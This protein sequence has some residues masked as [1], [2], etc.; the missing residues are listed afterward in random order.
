MIHP[1]I[2]PSFIDAACIIQ[3]KL[4]SQNNREAITQSIIEL[5][6]FIYEKYP[7]VLNISIPGYPNYQR[8]LVILLINIDNSARWDLVNKLD[9]E[10]FRVI[11]HFANLFSDWEH[12]IIDS[13]T[14]NVD[15]GIYWLELDP[16]TFV[17]H[18]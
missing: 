6:K 17:T 9:Y 16:Q 10:Y 2:H 5:W 15:E 11:E 18:A 1:S 8:D 3:R 14:Y 4:A 7:H 13:S 12:I